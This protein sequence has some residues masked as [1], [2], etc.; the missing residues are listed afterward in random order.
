MWA[1]FVEEELPCQ[2]VHTNFENCFVVAVMEGKTKL[3]INFH[4][5]LNVSMTKWV[6]SV[7]DLLDTITI[8]Y[9]MPVPFNSQTLQIAS[10]PI[11]SESYT[12]SNLAFL[13]SFIFMEWF[14]ALNPS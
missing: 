6:D 9:N 1:A 5:L 13:V 7:L 8:C 3:I 4:S 2:K 11:C 14:S 10:L 12:L